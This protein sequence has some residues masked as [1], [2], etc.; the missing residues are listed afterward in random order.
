MLKHCLSVYL[1]CITWL[2]VAGQHDDELRKESQSVQKNNDIVAM[3]EE[4]RGKLYGTYPSVVVRNQTEERVQ[5]AAEPL[6]QEAVN[7]SK[8]FWQQRQRQTVSPG[9]AYN[10]VPS[11]YHS[12]RSFAAS[13]PKLPPII[14]FPVDNERDFFSAMIDSPESYASE[15]GGED[16]F[17]DTAGQGLL[18]RTHPSRPSIAN[19]SS[20]GYIVRRADF[21]EPDPVLARQLRGLHGRSLR[22]RLKAV[23]SCCCDR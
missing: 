22:S 10:R 17:M 14:E 12:P 4:I 6:S 1:F 9:L 5:I 8:K 18:P 15:P 21:F 7:V 20:P 13:S 3:R 11:T 23:F 2:L 16:A 19:E